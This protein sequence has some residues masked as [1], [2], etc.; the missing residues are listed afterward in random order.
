MKNWTSANVMTFYFALHLISGGKLDICGRDHLLFF[1][2]V[3]V[4]K[5]H[6]NLKGVRD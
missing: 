2:N 3:G 1:L 4:R 5:L 6:N